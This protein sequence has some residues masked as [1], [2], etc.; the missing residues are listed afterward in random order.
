VYGETEWYSTVVRARQ[1]IGME[2]WKAQLYTL[3]KLKYL[4]PFRLFG[5]LK[6]KNS[7][8]NG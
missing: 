1:H 6:V 8:I 7:G 4:N 3:E 5:T 2:N